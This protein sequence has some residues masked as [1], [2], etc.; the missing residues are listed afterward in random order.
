MRQHIL[1]VGSD[2]FARKITKSLPHLRGLACVAATGAAATEKWEN[3]RCDVVRLHALAPRRA[4]RRRKDSRALRQYED[5]RIRPISSRNRGATLDPTP[6]LK[7]V[8][9]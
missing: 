9:T 6:F 7:I 4:R 5:F 3:G 8:V 2:S 1:N